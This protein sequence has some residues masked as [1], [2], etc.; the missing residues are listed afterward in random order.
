LL[1]KIQGIV[2]CARAAGVST[3]VTPD[4]TIGDALM[5]ASEMLDEVAEALERLLPSVSP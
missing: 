1:F 2:L 3:L 5:V 4:E